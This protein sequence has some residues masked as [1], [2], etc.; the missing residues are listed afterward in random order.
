VVQLRDNGYLM[1]YCAPLDERSARQPEKVLASAGSS[2]DQQ[3]AVLQQ[4]DRG[5]A[6][7][8]P[9]GNAAPDSSQQAPSKEPAWEAFTEADAAAE[10]GSDTAGPPTP[11]RL[12]RGS[13]DEFAPLPDFQNPSIT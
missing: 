7:D 8:Q 3:A 6:G 10:V 13:A 4:A 2:G 12:P 9:T 5:Q 1:L 11:P